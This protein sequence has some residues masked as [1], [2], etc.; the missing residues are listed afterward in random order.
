M[1]G[2]LKSGPMQVSVSDPDLMFMNQMNKNMD[3]VMRSTPA[4]GSLNM[5]L[6]SEKFKNAF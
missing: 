6:C 4:K 5:Q 3:W 2:I 1:V